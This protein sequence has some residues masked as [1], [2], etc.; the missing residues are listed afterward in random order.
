M[1]KRT[2]AIILVIVL[3]L[4]GLWFSRGQTT[5][6]PAETEQPQITSCLIALDEIQQANAASAETENDEAQPDAT[7][8]VQDEAAPDENGAY[9]TKKDVAAYLAAYGTLPG[10]FITKTEARALGWSGG[11]LDDYAYGMCIGGDRFGNYEG[12]LPEA[13]G[14]EYYE[15]DVDTL[16]TDSRGAK[17]IVYSSDGLIYYTED[18]YESFALLY[19]NP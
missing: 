18:H 12:L 17:R 9:T 8:P 10:N 15:C 11:G 5:Q 1:K 19:G 16:H 3:A 2:L 7:A 13:G 6:Q 4:A 14:R